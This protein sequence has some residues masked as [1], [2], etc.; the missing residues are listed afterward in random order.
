MGD[1]HST[2]QVVFFCVSLP[3]FPNSVLKFSRH[4]LQCVALWHFSYTAGE[5]L[6]FFPRPE[7]MRP[8]S[9]CL[10][11]RPRQRRVRQ[12]IPLATPPSCLHGACVCLP[13]S[14]WPASTGDRAVRQLQRAVACSHAFTWAGPSSSLHPFLESSWPAGCPRCSLGEPSAWGVLLSSG[15]LVCISSKL[16]AVA[17]CILLLLRWL[18]S[19]CTSL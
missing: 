13:A 8:T 9:G 16:S 12:P 18:T 17:C 6:P 19:L 10:L 11:E 2:V 15:V 5:A 4:I 1:A 7:T 14:L 3:K